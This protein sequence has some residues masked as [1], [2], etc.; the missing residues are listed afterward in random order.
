MDKNRNSKGLISEL[1]DIL[2]VP[3]EVAAGIFRITVT[4]RYKVHIENHRGILEYSNEVMRINCGKTI[5]KIDGENLEIKR[6]NS[7]EMLICGDIS[8]VVLEK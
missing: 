4:S 7:S 1:S 5:V 8:D 2:D 3:G 6:I